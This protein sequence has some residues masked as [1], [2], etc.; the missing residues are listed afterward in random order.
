MGSLRY[1]RQK[2]EAG[3]SMV[4]IGLLL[5]VLVG[6]LAV[7]MDGGY[8][9]LQRRGSQ[10][11]ADAGALAGAREM[12]RTGDTAVAIQAALDYAITRNGALEADVSIIDGEVE[13]T[14]R[15]PFPTFF[16]RVFGR[17]TITSSAIAAAKC[18]PPGSATGVLPIAWNCPPDETYP[19]ATGIMNCDMQY[20]PSQRYIIMNSR[21]TG[22]DTTYC[23]SDGGTVDCDPDGDGYDELLAGGNRSWL[24]LT[25]SGSDAGDG[26]SELVYWIENGFAGTVTMHTWFAGQ[27]G[28]SNNVFMA[29]DSLLWTPV[30]LPVYDAV[31]DG[32]PPAG[33]HDPPDAVVTSNGASTTYYHVI[34]F[35]IFVP[36]CVRATGADKD[37]DLYNYFAGEGV[38]DPD[39]KT[40]EGYFM[41]GTLEG[42]G[43][44]GELYAG[45]YTLY[46]SK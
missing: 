38:L 41:E 27:P 31:I 3:Q 37:C 43:G 7:V 8:A 11:A 10:T 9:Y 39:D 2:L 29:V 45:A 44:I 30:I 23:I 32:I 14:A 24:D 20:D 21:K 1:K 22:D 28:V 12:C 15:I 5:V 16:G 42:L 6:M 18:F 46:L 36:T 40:I 17:D 13:V 35:S 34:T 26:S 4:L 33:Y 25:G 19:D